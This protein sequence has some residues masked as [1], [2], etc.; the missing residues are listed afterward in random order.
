MLREWCD[1][2]GPLTGIRVLDLSRILAGPWAGQ[3]LADLGAEVI[4][5]ERPDTGDDTR[6]WGP[7]FLPDAPD[8][9]K[10]DAAYFLSANRGKASVAIDMSDP[11]GQDLIRK[12]AGECDI[13]LENFKVGGLAKYGLDYDAL[14]ETH[15]HL[16]YCS[17]T[18]FGQ[19]GPFRQRAGYDFMIQGMG[20]IMSVTGQPDGKPGGEPMKCGVAFAD[21]FTGLYSVIGILGALHARQQTG[22]GQH[23]DMA[24]LDCQVGVLANQNLNYLVGGTPPP[25]LGNAHPNIVP[26]QALPTSDGFVIIAIGT[27]RQ[28]EK[29]CEI[30]GLEDV[31][32]DP[33]FAT[34]RD[35]VENRDALIPIIADAL[36]TRTTDAWVSALEDHAVPCGPILDIAQ[37][38]DHPQVQARGLRIDMDRGAGEH[39]PGVANPI[40]YSDTTLEFAK[41]PPRLGEDTRDVLMRVGGLTDAEFERLKDEGIVGA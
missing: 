12:L 41:A 36:R 24:L 22:R 23:I 4:K 11:R 32:H 27:N 26:Y 2:A 14:S 10:G 16:I 38:F 33:R 30:A 35:R 29:F 13:L 3:T 1:M 37:V 25:R 8:G 19:T 20:G 39:I 6:V 7:P 18:G 17:I 28:F 15:P 9:S 21:L 31:A 40:R 5:V 34:N